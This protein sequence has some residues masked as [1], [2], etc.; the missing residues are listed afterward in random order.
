MHAANGTTE[1][2]SLSLRIIYVEDAISNRRSK[3]I[4]MSSEPKY[5]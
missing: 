5:M 4:I 3:S 1:Q 2:G